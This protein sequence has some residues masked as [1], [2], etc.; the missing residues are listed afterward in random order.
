MT[1]PPDDPND[2]A[3]GGDQ[4]HEWGAG[5]KLDED[6]AWRDIVAHYGEPSPTDDPGASPE[7]GASDKPVEANPAV[8]PGASVEP[9]ET[10]DPPPTRDERLRNLFR[11]SWNDP[12]DTE[13]SWED[14][15]HFV[16]PVPPPPPEPEPRRKAAW[17]GLFG[18]PTIMLVA[19][20]LGWSLP[21]WI[22]AGLA[23]GFVGGFVYLVATMPNR[24]PGDGSGDNGA[25]V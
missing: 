4:G 2:P 22:T 10:P 17:M 1:Q 21:G 6:A 24:Y 20:V 15:G 19:V 18:A 16:P 3:H 14:E 8:E 7:P 12:L 23:A 5:R 9:V 11:P 13:A 25:V